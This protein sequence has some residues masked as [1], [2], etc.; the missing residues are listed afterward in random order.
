MRTTAALTTALKT[1]RVLGRALGLDDHRS[2]SH[3]SSFTLQP[4]ALLGQQRLKPFDAWELLAVLLEGEVE[5]LKQ[6]FAFLVCLSGSNDGDIHAT[7]MINFVKIDL[8]EDGL[9]SHAQ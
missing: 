5:A 7:H 8:G 6:S 3:K 2:L 9:L 4:L 1:R